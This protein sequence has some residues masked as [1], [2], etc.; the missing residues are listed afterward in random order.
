LGDHER[1]FEAG[2]RGRELALLLVALGQVQQRA[3]ARVQVIALLELG[4]GVLEVTLLHQAARL[5]VQRLGTG[6]VLGGLGAG[7]P[8]GQGERENRA[9]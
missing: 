7:F 3:A 9:Q 8:G 6:G 5:F 1:L 2:P 4:T